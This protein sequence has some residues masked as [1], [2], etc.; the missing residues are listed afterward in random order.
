MRK[1]YYI[2]IIF[3]LY[4]FLC[5]SKYRETHTQ[6]FQKLNFA[7]WEG[8]WEVCFKWGGRDVVLAEG[9]PILGTPPPFSMFLAP[10]HIING[11]EVKYDFIIIRTCCPNSILAHLLYKRICRARHASLLQFCLN[12]F[13]L[14]FWGG[15]K[16]LNIEIDG[17]LR[18]MINIYH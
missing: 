3:T 12:F 9:Y 6:F 7:K 14:L 4:S 10:S 2:I 1:H 11:D 16:T 15:G 17:I 13:C 8:T 18:E 5:R